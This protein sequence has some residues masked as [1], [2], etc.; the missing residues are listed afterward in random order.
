MCGKIFEQKFMKDQGG[1]C[2]E[3]FKKKFLEHN[4]HVHEG[5]G[6]LFILER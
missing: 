5:K 1:M 2:W 3:S 6:A 4:M